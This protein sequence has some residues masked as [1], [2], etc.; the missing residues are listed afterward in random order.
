[1]VENLFA[2]GDWNCGATFRFQCAFAENVSKI[3]IR[4]VVSPFGFSVRKEGS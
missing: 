1:M 3:E 2:F 4:I